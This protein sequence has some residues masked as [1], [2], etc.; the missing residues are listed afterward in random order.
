MT[1]RHAAPVPSSTDISVAYETEFQKQI[2]DFLT[3]YHTT[4]TYQEAFS[5]PLCD[6]KYLLAAETVI[7][8]AYLEHQLSF[9]LASHHI[10]SWM[11]LWRK[12]ADEIAKLQKFVGQVRYASTL[13]ALDDALE[14]LDS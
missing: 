11:R 6:W 4:G 12:Q 1:G 14:E 7:D 13:D 3:A 8:R 9:H 2:N 5:C 10:E